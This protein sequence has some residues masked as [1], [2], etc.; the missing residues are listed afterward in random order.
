MTSASD[1]QTWL[2]QVTIDG[3]AP[4]DLDEVLAIEHRSFPS[5][6]S[7]YSYE[8]ELRN[9][10]SHYFAARHEGAVVGYVGMWAIGTECHVTT[11]AVR[12]D[13]RRRGL[14]SRLLRHL[15]EFAERRCA[16]HVTLEVRE[17]NDAARRLYMRFGFEERGRLPRYY[18]DTGENGVV[19]CRQLKQGG[20]CEASE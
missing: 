4:E 10:N 3:M 12:P 17:R 7:R 9:R 14:G 13:R 11:L 1:R 16:T 18:G 15:I 6:W 5:A 19:M 8:R 20:R 2:G